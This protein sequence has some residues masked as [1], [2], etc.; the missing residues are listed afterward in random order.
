MT[1]ED[2]KKIGVIILAVALGLVAAILIGNHIQSEVTQKTEALAKEYEKTLKPLQ[3]EVQTLRAE[4]VEV[5]KTA[6]EQVALALQ[7]QRRLDSQANV[8]LTPQ[9]SL[10]VKT[11]AGKRAITVQIDSL[12]A[13]GG[14][15]NP[16]DFVDILANMS[17]PKAK[18]PAAGAYGMNDSVTAM[19]FQNV[20]ILAI[21]ANLNT[22]SY[23]AQQQAGSLKVTFA[24]EPEESG[25][26]SFVQQ[27]GR[28]QLALRPPT[29]KESYTLQASNWQTLSDYVM[30]KQGIDIRPPKSE[31][32]VQPAAQEVKPYIQVFRGGK[33]L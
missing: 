21:D 10:A 25:L 6:G 27:N 8:N 3:Q 32:Q 28:L 23:A 31:A 16:G 13:V 1:S 9:T 15:I 18:V 7:Q 26:L 11:P 4:V 30:E 14:L 29:E 22:G 20:Q 12:S 19:V 33:E 24:L 2:K 5:K 17:I